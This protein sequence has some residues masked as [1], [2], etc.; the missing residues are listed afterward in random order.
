MKHPLNFDT[1][2]TALNYSKNIFEQRRNLHFRSLIADAVLQFEFNFLPYIHGSRDYFMT[3][4]MFL[5]PSFFYFNPKAELDGETYELRDM[6]TEGQFRGEE[7]NS[8]QWAIAYGIGFKTDLSYRWSINLELS[9]RKLFT[10]YIDDVSGAY[11][12]PED[13]NFISNGINV[14]P[15]LADKSTANIG[16]PG[17]QRGTSKDKDRFMFVGV[18]LTYTINT[19]KCPKVL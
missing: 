9:A 3:P 7:Y 10:D 11:A 1:P 4:Y 19:L 8:T 13:V 15:S 17:K 2:Y 16:I 18:S 14:G 5:G 12:E 6:G